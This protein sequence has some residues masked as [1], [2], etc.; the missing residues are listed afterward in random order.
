[1]QHKLQYNLQDSV[2]G[3]QQYQ[4]RFRNARR[5]LGVWN[6]YALTSFWVHERVN[7]EGF[8]T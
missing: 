1:M 8:N 3:N 2:S 7:V 6:F 4:W 5:N